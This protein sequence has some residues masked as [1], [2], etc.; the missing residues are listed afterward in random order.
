MVSGLGGARTGAWFVLVS[1][2]F[3]R[4]ISWEVS[5]LEQTSLLINVSKTFENQYS[6]GLKA[7]HQSIL[8]GY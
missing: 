5:V 7:S 6:L 8:D 2:E 3:Q 4:S 1:N